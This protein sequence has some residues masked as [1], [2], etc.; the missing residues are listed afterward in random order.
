MKAEEDYEY[1][2]CQKLYF[3]VHPFEL[4]GRCQVLASTLLPELL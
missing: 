1:L 3:K 2:Q 4:G